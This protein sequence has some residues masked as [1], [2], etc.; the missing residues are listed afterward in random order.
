MQYCK[1]WCLM[2]VFGSKIIHNTVR[3]HDQEN[4]EKKPSLF[5]KKKK[6]KL[7][8]RNCAPSATYHTAFLV[9]LV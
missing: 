2:F 8:V 5:C 6:K 3:I 1:D 7:R 9:K 4:A